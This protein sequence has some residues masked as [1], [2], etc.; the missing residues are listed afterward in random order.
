MTNDARSEEIAKVKL[1]LRLTASE[2]SMNKRQ[3]NPINV[4]FRG[5]NIFEIF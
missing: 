3:I 1:L 2:N 5:G 4:E